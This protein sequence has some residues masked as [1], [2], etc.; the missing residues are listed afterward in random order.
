MGRLGALY[1]FE[2]LGLILIGVGL[3]L[4]FRGD[5]IPDFAQSPGEGLIFISSQGLWLLFLEIAGATAGVLG[6]LLLF[7]RFLI[8]AHW[9]YAWLPIGASALLAYSTHEYVCWKCCYPKAGDCE[10]YMICGAIDLLALAIVFYV[11]QFL[12][13][14]KLEEI[15]DTKPG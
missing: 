15:P 14:R 12:A 7:V 8:A 10:L 2:W 9:W 4:I 6:V 5:Y 3:L 11:V 1:W 13:R